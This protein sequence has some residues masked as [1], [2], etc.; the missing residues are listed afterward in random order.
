MRNR[1]RVLIDDA[2]HGIPTELVA[3]RDVIANRAHVIA[4]VNITRWLNPREHAL[5]AARV[6]LFCL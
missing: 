2:I 4:D 6:Y 5:H 3:Q 1:D